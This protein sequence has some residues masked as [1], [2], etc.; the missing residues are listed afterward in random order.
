MAV[1]KAKLDKEFKENQAKLAEK[2]ATEQRFANWVYQLPG[3]TVDS[4]LKPKQEL[5]VEEKKVDEK[6][7]GAPAAGK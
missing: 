2:L 7:E 5:L 1:E 4:L 6:K 3:D